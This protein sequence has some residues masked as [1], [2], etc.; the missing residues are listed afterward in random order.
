M[1]LTER[2][3]F[4]PV[5]ESANINTGATGKSINMTNYHHAVFILAFLSDLNGDAVL[6]IKSGATDT[7]ETTPVTF[8][9]RGSPQDFGVAGSDILSAELSTTS[10]IL[11]EGNYQDRIL[12]CEVDA[13]DM[14]DGQEWL[15]LSLDNTATGGSVTCVALL[16][17]R[18]A[19]KVFKTAI[20][21]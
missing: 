21:T 3:H 2:M 4:V 5:F 17:P 7:A 9:H 1:R 18:Y 12:V 11:T 6:T 15:T 19:S 8:H 13:D 14:A 20:A 10:L 16:E